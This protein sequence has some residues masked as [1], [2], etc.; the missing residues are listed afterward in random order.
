MSGMIILIMVMC[1][2]SLDS[3]S[4]DDDYYN[5]LRGKIKLNYIKLYKNRQKKIVKR[6][7]KETE[8]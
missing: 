8:R 1:D 3:Y 7:E 2:D 4:N 5:N 6:R